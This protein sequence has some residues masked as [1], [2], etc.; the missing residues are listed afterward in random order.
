VLVDRADLKALS[1]ARLQ[2]ARALL[3]AGHHMG[4]YYLAGYSVECALKACIAGTIR[5]DVWPDR[6]FSQSIHTHSIEK[7][8]GFAGLKQQFEADLGADPQ[9]ESRWGHLSKWS[10]EDRY[11]RDIDATDAADLIDAIE[12]PSSGILTWIKRQPQW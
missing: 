8:M 12:N 3:G 6:G 5:P 11:S 4:G 1:E 10:E 2:E 9:L 7:L